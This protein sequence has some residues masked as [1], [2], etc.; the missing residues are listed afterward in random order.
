[1]SKVEGGGVRLTPLKASCN[2]FFWK[3]S[4]VKKIG[5][6]SKQNRLTKLANELTNYYNY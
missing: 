3:A 1:M 2:Y 6:M 5:K 4:R